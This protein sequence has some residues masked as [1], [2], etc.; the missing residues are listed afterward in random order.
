VVLYELVTGRAPFSAPTTSDLLVAILEREPPPLRSVARGLPL[1]L[2]WIIEKALEKDPNLRYHSIADLRVDL[3]RLKIALEAGKLTS[4]ATAEGGVADAV[5]ER[6]LTDDA[7]EVIALGRVSWLTAAVA[8]AAAILLGIAMSYYFV[9]RPG[10]DLPL[11][12]PEGGVITKARD[13][14][15]GFGYSDLGSRTNASF[16]DGTDIGVITEMAGLSAARDAIREGAPVASWRAGIAHTSNP[17]GSLEPQPGDYGVRFDP[18]GKLLA[19]GTGYATDASITHADRARATAI[20]LEAIKKA[21]GIDADGY[22]LEVVERSFPAGKTEMTWRSRTS[23]RYGHVDQFRVNLQG[24]KL[25]LIERSLQRPRDYKAPTTA[26]PMRIFKG[27][28]IAVLVGVVLIGW[29]FGLYFLFK[30]KNWDALTRRLPLAMC[31]LVVLQVGISSFGSPGVF[32]SLLGMIAIAVLLIGTVLPA[33]SG[34]LLWLT[35]RAPARMWAAEQLT[36]GRVLV[37]TVATSLVDGVAG[38]AGIAAIGV[39]A[40]WAALGV[41]GFE[42]SI[43]RELHVVD[44]GIGAMI[45]DTFSGSAFIILGIA[46]VVETCDRWRVNPILSTIVI[47]IAGGLI[48]GQDQEAILPALPLVA[49]LS[50]SAAIAVMLYRRRGFL[51]AWVA[52]LTSGLLTDAMALRSLDDPDLLRTSNILITIVVVIAAAGAWGV[53]RS[54]MKKGGE[55]VPRHGGIA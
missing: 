10:A 37:N 44:A 51:A 13:A 17:N 48:A 33:L 29:G 46:L 54:L 3:Q 21:F 18:G 19:F 52:G 36:R 53:G 28:G 22:E 45:G 41:S 8:A 34:V 39:L 2:E 40:D 55:A 38:G 7:P 16:I 5:V 6:E 23:T 25:V 12:L 15:A 14:V 32:Q 9:A 11:T 49:G 26:L 20:G 30:T 43:S 35:R 4:A 1:Q 47:A 27:S 50:L 42:P 24:E 31:A